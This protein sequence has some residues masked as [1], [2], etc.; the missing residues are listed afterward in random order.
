[1]VGRG[2]IARWFERWRSGGA[3]DDEGNGAVSEFW[4]DLGTGAIEE[5]RQSPGA[6]RM[7]P[8]PTREAAQAAFDTAAAR[9]EAWD[10]EDRRWR[11]EDRDD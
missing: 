11:E 2:P 8:Y 9:N 1:M 5:G 7:G 10:E 6:R 3:G 4:V